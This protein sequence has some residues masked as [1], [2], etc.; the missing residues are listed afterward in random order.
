MYYIK[1]SQ[2]VLNNRKVVYDITAY[3][4]ADLLYSGGTLVN[5]TV[6]GCMFISKSRKSYF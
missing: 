6:L 4:T 2:I 1:S 3:K 5:D